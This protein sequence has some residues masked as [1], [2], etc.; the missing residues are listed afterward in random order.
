M[1]KTNPLIPDYGP[2]HDYPTEPI[3]GSNP[4]YRCCACG[5]SDPQI[6]GTL[7]GHFSGCDWVA[8]KIYT[9][10]EAQRVKS[11]K[12]EQ[13]EQ[14]AQQARAAKLTPHLASQAKNFVFGTGNAN[15]QLVLVGEAPGAKEDE[16]AEPFVG[17]SGQL[18]NKVLHNAGLSR[19]DVYITNTVKYRPPNNRNPK[20]EEIASFL[21]ILLQ[22][23]AIIKP[24]LVVTLGKYP[25]K[26]LSPKLVL[27][28]ARGK[29]YPSAQAGHNWE[30]FPTY[31]PAATLYNRS[32]EPVLQADFQA[33]AKKLKT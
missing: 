18:L 33:I 8:S 16:K 9:L 3:G 10:M 19:Q 30:L 32:L 31:H 25:L 24:K 5:A 11:I 4:Y 15:A 28:E 20:H 2:Y 17:Q 22:E 23:L 13:L 1:L 7:S 6:N 21:P 26:A 29:S 27:R 12:Q 14:L